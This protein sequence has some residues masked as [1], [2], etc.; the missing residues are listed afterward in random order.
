MCYNP[1]TIQNQA[2]KSLGGFEYVQVP[3]GHCADCSTSKQIDYFLR[4]YSVYLDM[5]ANWSIWFCTFTFS[6]EYIPTSHVYAKT[7]DLPDG[8][9]EYEQISKVPV[10]CFNHEL[11]K[12]FF[13]SL[14]QYYN[15]KG[16]ANVQY[17]ATCEFGHKHGRPHYHAILFVPEQ[18]GYW[19][20]F[21]DIVNAYWHYGYTYNAQISHLDGVQRERSISKAIRYVTK[22]VCKD[23]SVQPFYLNHGDDIVLFAYEPFQYKP[24]VFTSNGFGASLQNRLSDVDY[25]IGKLTISVDGKPKTYSIPQ[26]LLRRYFT[27]SK[28]VH[29]EKVYIKDFWHPVGRLRVRRKQHTEYIH[30]Y[31]DI[32]RQRAESRFRKAYQIAAKDM[33]IPISEKSYVDYKM[34]DF[35]SGLNEIPLSREVSASMSKKD[36]TLHFTYSEI[37]E[38]RKVLQPCM[39]DYS[40]LVE[41]DT[42]R[43]SI[44]HQ[45]ELAR[46]ESNTYN[47]YNVLANIEY[48]NAQRQEL[49]N[50]RKCKLAEQRKVDENMFYN[51]HTFADTE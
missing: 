10:K 5:P 4:T 8:S 7:A 32:L 12:R 19:K 14:N 29:T 3:C 11:L 44:R 43:H 45:V 48:I 41:N 36:P 17:L 35:D 9:K 47:I 31:K 23:S 25:R 39:N 2:Y 18:Y 46:L 13:K 15:R 33:S 20:Q 6:D 49:R 22:Y 27:F 21:A 26:Y 1:L 38:D 24:R 16:L 28:I 50:I 30:G 37:Y 51:S 34:L 42:F 40:N